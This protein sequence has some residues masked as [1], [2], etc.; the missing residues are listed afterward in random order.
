MFEASE[1]GMQ[2]TSAQLARD[3]LDMPAINREIIYN[4]VTKEDPRDIEEDIYFVPDS[5]NKK[6]SVEQLETLKK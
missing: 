5:Y 1:S 3:Q 6:L 4:T 2:K